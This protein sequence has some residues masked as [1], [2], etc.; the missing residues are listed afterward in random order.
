MLKLIQ[1]QTHEMKM[2][3][4]YRCNPVGAELKWPRS[5]SVNNGDI[6]V[7]VISVVSTDAIVVPVE[8]LKNLMTSAEPKFQ[9]F[10]LAMIDIIAKDQEKLEGTVEHT[11]PRGH[12]L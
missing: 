8:Y 3:E 1:K 5:P 10:I 6:D 7:M 11:G 4:R 2:G 12:Y 9:A